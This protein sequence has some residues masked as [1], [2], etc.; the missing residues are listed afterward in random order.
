MK[1]SL[2]QDSAFELL[3]LMKLITDG[4]NNNDKQRS[5]MKQSKRKKIT[6]EIRQR[7]N[8]SLMK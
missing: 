8:R 1:G 5:R 3:K 4:K 7:C 6:C 2:E